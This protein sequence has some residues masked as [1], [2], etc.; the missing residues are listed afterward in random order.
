MALGH[1]AGH[2][3]SQFPV[4]LQSGPLYPFVSLGKQHPNGSLR[5][6]TCT[7]GSGLPVP[8]PPPPGHSEAFCI[9]TREGT[10]WEAQTLVSFAANDARY[11]AHF[12][13]HNIPGTP[14]ATKTAKEPP[15]L[16]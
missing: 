8:A 4:Y 16:D 15:A 14:G 7:Y 5:R 2:T 3:S 13:F 12:P 6:K 9:Y 10:L 1:L 11:A